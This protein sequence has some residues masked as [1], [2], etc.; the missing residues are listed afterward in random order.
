MASTW[1]RP[2]DDQIDTTER[3][4]GDGERVGDLFADRAAGLPARWR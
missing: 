3:E 2:D 4:S 1:S